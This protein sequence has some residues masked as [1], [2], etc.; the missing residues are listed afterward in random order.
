MIVP[1]N[2]VPNL[3]SGLPTPLHARTP[4]SD[5]VVTQLNQSASRPT[6]LRDSVTVSHDHGTGSIKAHEAGLLNLGTRLC[7]LATV[8]LYFRN[9][10][11]ANR[12][13]ARKGLLCRY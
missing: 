4:A 5:R 13:V 6:H 10:V 3:L 9:H 12:D 8:V 2:D 11:H 7:A 1:A